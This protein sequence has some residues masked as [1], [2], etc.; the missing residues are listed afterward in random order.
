MASF[1][2]F[3]LS[4]PTG[5]LAQ[6]VQHRHYF[7]ISQRFSNTLWAFPS[8]FP[9]LL[10]V[11]NGCLIAYKSISQWLLAKTEQFLSIFLEAAYL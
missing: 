4:Q 5:T 11:P 7:S 10:A 8:G 1:P 2:N 9:F 3:Y 6:Q